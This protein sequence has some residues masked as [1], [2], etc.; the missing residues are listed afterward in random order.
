[1]RPTT[2]VVRRLADDFVTVYSLEDLKKYSRL[3]P[4][5]QTLPQEVKDVLVNSFQ[6]LDILHF[7]TLQKFSELNLPQGPILFTSDHQFEDAPNTETNPSPDNNDFPGDIKNS[8]QNPISPAINNT[9][10]PPLNANILPETMINLP[11][12]F[13]A[14]ADT[15]IDFPSTL[16]P[17]TMLSTQ[18]KKPNARNQKTAKPKQRSPILTRQR[19]KENYPPAISDSDSDSDTSLSKQVQFVQE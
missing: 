6:E 19:A 5:F 10:S 13:L 9:N 15:N 7:E 14:N 2:A 4:Q 8:L 17:N 11:Q 16:L 12:H 18:Q 3:D 1:M